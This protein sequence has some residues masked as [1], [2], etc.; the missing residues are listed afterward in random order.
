M[1]VAL[2]AGLTDD[3]QFVTFG[4]SELPDMV[5]ARMIADRF[6]LDHVDTTTQQYAGAA[7]FT[8]AERYR[9][10]VHRTCGA[11]PCSDANEPVAHSGWVV[12]GHLGE[13]FRTA[14]ARLV[15]KPPDDWEAATARVL[16]S[17]QPGKAGLV[18]TEHAAPMLEQLTTYV[19]EAAHR[20]RRPIDLTHAFNVRCRYPRWQGPLVDHHERRVLALCSPDALRSALA[21]GDARDAEAV[22][23]RIIHDAS[24]D[25]AALPFANDSWRGEGMVVSEPVRGPTTARHVRRRETDHQA[26]LHDL[27]RERPANPA[28]GVLD[29]DAISAGIEDLAELP[30]LP[31]MQLLGAITALIWHGDT[32]SPSRPV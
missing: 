29:P 11:S 21:V 25:L 2:R 17:R 27:V 22:H 23:H 18:R 30:P 3:L 15:D 28:F 1:A 7:A 9:R 20:L 32:T 19:A 24:P 31:R 12:S 4:P 13:L 26:V 14:S 16:Q 5:V 10:H 8:T 6:G